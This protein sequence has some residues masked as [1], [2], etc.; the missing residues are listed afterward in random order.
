MKFIPTNPTIPLPPQVA[1][2]ALAA[3]DAH[4]ERAWL[5]VKPD[6]DWVIFRMGHLSGSKNIVGWT[7][8]LVG[9]ATPVLD[10]G[11]FNLES[12]RVMWRQAIR[13]GAVLWGWTEATE[14]RP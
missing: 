11:N 14:V 1:V 12:A 5:L 6:G 3:Y 4:G 2:E 13:E 10:S 9:G 8:P 7:S